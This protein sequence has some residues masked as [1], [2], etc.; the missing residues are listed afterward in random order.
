MKIMMRLLL[1]SIWM[2]FSAPAF[3]E[4]A[5]QL[6]KCTQDEEASDADVLAAASE[7]LQATKEV[8]GGKN[9]TVSVHFPIAAPVGEIDFLLVVNAPSLMEWGEFMDNYEGSAVAKV[10]KRFAEIA[11]CAESTLWES[12]KIK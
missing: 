8:Q 2:I 6:Y 3:S 9:L 12:V 11:D 10:D 1:V 5:S 4:T 7:W